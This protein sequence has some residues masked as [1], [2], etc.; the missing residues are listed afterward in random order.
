[1]P[2]T[3]INL[4]VMT[5]NALVEV[6][7]ERGIEIKNISK[8]NKRDLISIIAQVINAEN[9]TKKERIR[10]AVTALFDLT[11]SAG[12]QLDALSTITQSDFL[13]TVLSVAPGW[14]HAADDA[15]VKKHFAW[16][17]S[18]Y[19]KNHGGLVR[20][21]LTDEQ[22]AERKAQAEQAKAAKLAAKEA[23]KT[24][25]AEPIADVG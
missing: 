4:T 17:K 13:N 3:A 8:T 20:P 1:M 15:K 5:K 16:Y 21:R 7:K 24:E 6:A 18:N 22:K 2:N 11:T 10:N 19:R 23:A 9:G 14:Q 12:K 25:D